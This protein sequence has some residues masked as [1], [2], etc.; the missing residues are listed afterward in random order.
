MGYGMYLRNSAFRI[1]R[2]NTAMALMMLQQFARQHS[3]LNHVDILDVLSSNT[4]ERAMAVCR[5]PVG[6]DS[7]GNIHEIEFD[8]DRL[9]GCYDI[10]C[11]IAPVVEGGSY[12][13]MQG[14]DDLIWRWVFEDGACH[15][16]LGTAVFEN[17]LGQ[18]P[19]DF[20]PYRQ[21]CI[22][23]KVEDVQAIRPDLSYE[24]AFSVL[25]QMK[26]KHDA[27]IGINLEV[28][29][30]TADWMFPASAIITS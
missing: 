14:E 2:E 4:F 6:G 24:Q 27:N 12:L 3:Q 28:I 22:I 21:I 16:V 5:Y 17:E 9:G 18:L 10:F 20:D 13:E 15:E 1:K 7:E 25:T 11:A 26:D 29:T 23:W 8:G 19:R 30:A